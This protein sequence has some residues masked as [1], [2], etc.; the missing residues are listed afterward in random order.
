MAKENKKDLLFSEHAVYA[1]QSRWE[2]HDII[3]DTKIAGID[4][5][6]IC[7][8]FEEFAEKWQALEVGHSMT[9]EWRHSSGSKR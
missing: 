5:V 7:A 1:A 8:K 3:P 6:R 4:I 2:K 9:L